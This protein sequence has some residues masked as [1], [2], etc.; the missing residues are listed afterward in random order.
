M[1]RLGWICNDEGSFSAASLVKGGEP[2][3]AP[4]CLLIPP[5]PPSW[6]PPG[7]HVLLLPHHPPPPRPRA[8]AAWIRAGTLTHAWGSSLSSWSASALEG[9][10]SPQ[11]T[12][13]PAGA[14]HE[15]FPWFS[16]RSLCWSPPGG[17]CPPRLRPPASSLRG[18][19]RGQPAPPAGGLRRRT[20][21]APSH[22]LWAIP[23]LDRLPLL[24]FVCRLTLRTL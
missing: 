2:R 4:S 22:C 18:A 10:R 7:H 23:P 14:L 8:R 21:Q 3:T 9:R 24:G 20:S 11:A 15:W 12:R 5:S 6:I 17:H 13:G 16:Q 1:G 19:A